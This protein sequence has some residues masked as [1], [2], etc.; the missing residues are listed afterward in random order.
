MVLSFYLNQLLFSSFEL[1][2]IETVIQ[3]YNKS[4]LEVLIICLYLLG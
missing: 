4:K 3:W 2:K 1:C